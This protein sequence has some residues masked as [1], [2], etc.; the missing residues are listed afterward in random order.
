MGLDL[1]YQSMLPG[2]AI[3]S[4]RVCY[5]KPEDYYSVYVTIPRARLSGTVRTPSGTRQVTGYGYSD[6]GVVTMM[7]YDYSKRWS[8]M[9]YFGEKYTLDIL[10]SPAP[11]KWGGA[12]VP[13]VLFAA[14]DKILYAGAKY[15]LTAGDFQVEPKFKQKYPNRVEFLIDQPGKVK[16]EGHYT[17]GTMMHCI[18]V[19][20]QLSFIERQIASLFAKSYIMRFVANV[21]G[22]VTLPD[23][24]TDQFAG[25]AVAEA[26]NLQ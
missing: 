26:I 22:T 13:L 17:M 24:T 25:P 19:L 11:P 3:N 9:R 1:Q 8:T 15:T 12:R 21:E 18:D 5:A 14:G 4:G 20:G 10:E 16:V 2:F 23:G 6:H 7:P